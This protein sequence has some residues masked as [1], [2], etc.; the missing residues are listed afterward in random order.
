MWLLIV[1]IIIILAVVFVVGG[2]K[3]TVRNKKS[4]MSVAEATR[5]AQELFEAVYG[6]IT[7]DQK[8]ASANLLLILAATCKPNGAQYHQIHDVIASYCGSLS[9]DAKSFKHIVTQHPSLEDVV[10]VLKQI[11]K[12]D[13]FFIHFL[14]TCWTIVSITESEDGSALL[15]YVF[16]ELG[17]SSEELINEIQKLNALDQMYFGKD[18]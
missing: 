17:Y 4:D 3:R 18:S 14:F 8:M 1:T 12:N 13:N 2:N 15:Q 6:H 5:R 10:G 9:I 7:Y 11:P 16:G